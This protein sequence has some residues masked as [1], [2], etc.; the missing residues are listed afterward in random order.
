MQDAQN[1]NAFGSQLDS[2][3]NNEFGTAEYQLFCAVLTSLF[4]HRRMGRQKVCLIFNTLV[5]LN[6]GL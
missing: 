1:L 4:P 2:I 3:N 6:G 5:M